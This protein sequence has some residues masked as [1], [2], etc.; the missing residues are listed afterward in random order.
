[1]EAVFRV[2]STDADME[3]LSLDSACI[4][5]HESANG[6]GK[7]GKEIA[8]AVGLYEAL[9]HEL[10]APGERE[11]ILHKNAERILGEVLK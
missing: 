4:K 7:T 3:N 6:R 11:N 10:P 2:L 1:M 5:V 9:G 8:D